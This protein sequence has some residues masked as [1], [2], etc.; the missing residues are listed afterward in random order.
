MSALCSLDYSRP[1]M[2]RRRPVP[3]TSM[4]MQSGSP[5]ELR[6]RMLDLESSADVIGTQR[7]HDLEE[8]FPAMEAAG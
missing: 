7:A 6:E 4:D 8:C 1:L 5:E 3:S 2:G